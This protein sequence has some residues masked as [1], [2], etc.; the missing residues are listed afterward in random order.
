M[1]DV[2]NGGHIGCGTEQL[3]NHFIHTF[4]PNI[5]VKKEQEQLHPDKITLKVMHAQHFF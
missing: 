4:A 3:R 2:P 1:H 5:D